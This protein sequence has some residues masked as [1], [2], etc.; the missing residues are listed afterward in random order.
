MYKVIVYG[1]WVCVHVYVY[2]V[3]IGSS[4]CRALTLTGRPNL[5]E[6]EMQFKQRASSSLANTYIRISLQLYDLP[7]Y[8]HIHTLTHL[9]SQTRIHIYL[10]AKSNVNSHIITITAAAAAAVAIAI[11]V[12]SSFSYSNKINSKSSPHEIHL[13]K[14]YFD[15]L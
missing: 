5:T 14:T 6:Y 10:D 2:M 3:F 11:A 7:T 9:H 12:A 15:L 4:N 8:A 1:V 13:H